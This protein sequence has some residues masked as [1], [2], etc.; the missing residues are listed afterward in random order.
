MRN[1]RNCKVNDSY[2][3]YHRAFCVE[4]YIPYSQ[5]TSDG[6]QPTMVIKCGDVM[7]GVYLLHNDKGEELI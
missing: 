6:Q 7:W 5:F 2:H 4:K 3:I 1:D